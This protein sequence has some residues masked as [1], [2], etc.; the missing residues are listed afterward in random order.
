MYISLFYI[1]LPSINITKY[2]WYLMCVM[3]MMMRM[4]TCVMCEQHYLL[5]MWWCNYIYFEQRLTISL[6][7]FY[8]SCVHIVFIYAYC[9]YVVLRTMQSKHFLNMWYCLPPV[10]F[11]HLL[12]AI[13][14]AYVIKLRK[15]KWDRVKFFFLFLKFKYNRDRPLTFLKDLITPSMN[16]LHCYMLYMYMCI[17]IA[18]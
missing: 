5:C 9:D 4:M 11:H 14:V 17:G 10:I 16:N 7:C 18:S 2:T 8:P 3:I 6:Q 15:I 13:F 12:F 1:F